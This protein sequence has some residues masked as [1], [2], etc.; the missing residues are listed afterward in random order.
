MNT[1]K[2]K[3]RRKLKKDNKKK[4]D[5]EK[6]VYPPVHTEFNIHMPKDKQTR[7]KEDQLKHV[8]DKF[9]LLEEL[10]R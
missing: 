3:S 9:D 1:F 6:K 8:S 10:Q 5:D 7:S 4:D 2:H